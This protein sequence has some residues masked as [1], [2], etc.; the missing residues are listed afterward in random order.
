MYYDQ[1]SGATGFVTGVLIGALLGAS[2]AL[3]TILDVQT[4]ADYGRVMSYLER[5]SVLESVDVESYGDGTLRLRVAARG[6]ARVLERVLALGGVLQPATAVGSAGALT[7][8]VVGDGVS[9]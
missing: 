8:E 6:D 1:E 3:L 7:F 2:V 5:Q 9:P 4:A